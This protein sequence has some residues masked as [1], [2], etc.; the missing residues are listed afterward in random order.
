[1][2]SGL[3]PG[4]RDAE[5]ADPEEPIGRPEQLARLVAVAQLAPEAGD[6]AAEQL[7]AAR[8]KLAGIG[9][10]VE[11]DHAA[12]AHER[13]VVLEVTANTVVRVVAVDQQKV[14]RLA[15]ERLARPP[16]RG[17]RGRGAAGPGE[18]PRPA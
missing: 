5:Q 10:V 14:K 13:P 9:D 6:L 11:G 7:V 3:E 17:P 16:E 15:A 1:M 12:R 4:V 18:P 2:R 8:G